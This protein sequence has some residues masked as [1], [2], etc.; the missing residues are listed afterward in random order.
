MTKFRTSSLSCCSDYRRSL[1]NSW[2]SVFDL[3][4]QMHMYSVCEYVYW[5]GEKKSA[6]MRHYR[7][8]LATEKKNKLNVVCLLTLLLDDRRPFFASLSLGRHAA[9]SHISQA[10][11]D[12][13]K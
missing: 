11:V 8:H 5:M 4:S 6:A 13:T 10:R 7:L 12:D 9:W 1:F 2:Y 3:T